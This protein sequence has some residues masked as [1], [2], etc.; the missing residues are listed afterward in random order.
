MTISASE[1]FCVAVELIKLSGGD[2]SSAQKDRA[3]DTVDTQPSSSSKGGDGTPA[4]ATLATPSY[5][6]TIT[7]EPTR[8]I[9][10]MPVA[11]SLKREFGIHRIALAHEPGAYFEHDAEQP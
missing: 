10:D 1:E 3:L 7:P 9:L 4:H 8:S 2:Y 6:K 5:L 11:H